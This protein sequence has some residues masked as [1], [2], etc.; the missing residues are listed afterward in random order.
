MI[1]PCLNFDTGSALIV[2]AWSPEPTY[3][4][5][6]ARRTKEG[7][8]NLQ[9]EHWAHSAPLDAT[10]ESAV[11]TPEGTDKGRQVG[12]K[13]DVDKIDPDGQPAPKKGAATAKPENGDIAPK[14]PQ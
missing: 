13:E 4:Y 6:A 5:G 7:G 1:Q 8:R 12:K 11:T 9:A 3:L 2:G 10:S 14:P